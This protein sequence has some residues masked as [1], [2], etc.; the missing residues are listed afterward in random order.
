[1]RIF[2]LAALAG[3]CLAQEN[4]ADIGKGMFRIYCAP[5]HGFRAQGGRG[6]DLSRGV[7]RSGEQDSDLM[8]TISKGVPGTEMGD[9]E[10]LGEENIRRVVAFIRSVNRH[11]NTTATG[12]AAH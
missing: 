4:P 8:R 9:Y 10:R 2:L 3:I 5:C 11:D 1:M 6:P 12:D 7:F